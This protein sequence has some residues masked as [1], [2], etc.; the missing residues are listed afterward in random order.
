MRFMSMNGAAALVNMP[1]DDSGVS[2][3]LLREEYFCKSPHR[4]GDTSVCVLALPEGRYAPRSLYDC[5]QSISR[6]LLQA[7]VYASETGLLNVGAISVDGTFILASESPYRNVCH[8]EVDAAQAHLAPK[9]SRLFEMAEAVDSE[10]SGAYRLPEE[11][12]ESSGPL[13]E[14][15]PCVWGN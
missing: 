1:L 14:G 12:T 7:L 6:R 15:V 3:V 2:C 9:E 10:V 8:D 13:G 5:G 11:L 4:A